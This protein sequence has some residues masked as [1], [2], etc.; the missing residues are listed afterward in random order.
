MSFKSENVGGNEATYIWH[1]DRDMTLLCSVISLSVLTHSTTRIGKATVES[2]D[3]NLAKQ[4]N[5]VIFDNIS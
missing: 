3:C 4:K 1:N 2:K 5:I